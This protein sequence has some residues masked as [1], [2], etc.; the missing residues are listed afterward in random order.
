MPV[1]PDCCRWLDA[2]RYGRLPVM[3][4]LLHAYNK[5][6]VA[7]VAYNGKGTSYGLMGH[8][9]LHWAAA[10]VDSSAHSSPI[11]AHCSTMCSQNT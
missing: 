2:A 5:D 8:T 9:A 3:K 10:K 11:A 1:A 4:A 7:L 6:K